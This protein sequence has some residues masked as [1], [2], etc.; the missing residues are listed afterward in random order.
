MNRS[1]STRGSKAKSIGRI[2]FAIFFA[3][4]CVFHFMQAEGF[5]KML[6][7][8]VPLRLPII[9]ATGILELVLGIMLL[10]PRT[11]RLTGIV[12]AIYLVL[13]FPANIYAAVKHIPA[14]GAESTAPAALWIRLIFQ[15]LLIWWVLWCSR[16]RPRKH[17]LP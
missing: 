14:P 5:A 9:Y 13:I 12:I 8:W 3:G 1:T 7:D 6:P 11:R 10:I 2:I 16:E 17:N 4:A 15:P